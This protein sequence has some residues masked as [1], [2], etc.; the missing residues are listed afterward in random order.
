MEKVHQ[1]IR[2][3]QSCLMKSCIMLNTKMKTTAKNETEKDFLKLV[4]NSVSRKIMKNVRNH[5][6]VN[7]V[8]SREKYIMYEIES[9]F[10]SMVPRS[11]THHRCLQRNSHKMY[12]YFSNS[13]I[14][15]CCKREMLTATSIHFMLSCP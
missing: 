12:S 11:N 2:F 15:L 3:E 4:N 9:N 8:R 7:L 6:Y 1:T 13:M 10:G 14:L 5:K